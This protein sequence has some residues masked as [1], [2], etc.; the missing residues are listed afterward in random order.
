M[1]DARLSELIAINGADTASDDLFLI[2]DV[3]AGTAGAKKIT[4]AEL[5]IALGA[6]PSGTAFTI[7]QRN[8]AGT[9]WEV[10]NNLK[11]SNGSIGVDLDAA[12]P[13]INDPDEEVVLDTLNRQAL[14]ANRNTAVD[15]G[16]D[17]EV[18]LEQNTTITPNM[19][20]T[21]THVQDVIS[22]TF[23]STVD[24]SAGF[25]GASHVIFRDTG[26]TGTTVLLPTSG[27]APIGS[28]FR[29]T[30][31]QCVST[32][33]PITIDAGDGSIMGV[34]G[35][36]STIELSSNGGSLLFQ[37]VLTGLWKVI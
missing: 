18:T 4:R 30:D 21:P 17:D 31:A 29:V 36:V 3:S 20:K 15:F 23:G 26:T 5:A 19:A 8:S 33:Y 27:N 9:G 11:Y 16:V 34:D 35:A 13:A 1:S 2:A 32:D 37:L 14:H 22:S 28:Y 6:L 10:A 12:N 7:I 25:A 24:L